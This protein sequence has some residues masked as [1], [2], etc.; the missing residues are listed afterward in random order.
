MDKLFSALTALKEAEIVGTVVLVIANIYFL[1]GLL[2]SGDYGIV[3]VLELA[4]FLICMTMLRTY[5][6]RVALRSHIRSL[7][8]CLKIEEAKKTS[9]GNKKDD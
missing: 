1:P 4:V 6:D 8:F 3:A 7:W 2:M 9:E 5:Y